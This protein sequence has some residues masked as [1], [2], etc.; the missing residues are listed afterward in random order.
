MREFEL[1]ALSVKGRSSDSKGEVCSGSCQ[2]AE[3]E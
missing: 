3:L 2:R 1:Y